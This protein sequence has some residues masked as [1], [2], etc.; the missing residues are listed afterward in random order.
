MRDDLTLP[1]KIGRAEARRCAKV[2]CLL[3][4]GTLGSS[5]GQFPLAV[6][7]DRLGTPVQHVVGAPGKALRIG[8]GESPG[9]ERVNPPPLPSVTPLAERRLRKGSAVA[10]EQER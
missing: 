1:S 10:C 5:H 7:K 8:S 6:C 2:V 9:M 3:S 4:G